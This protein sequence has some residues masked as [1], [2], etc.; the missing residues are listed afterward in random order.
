[1]APRQFSRLPIAKLPEEIMEKSWGAGLLATLRKA[2]CNQA[3]GRYESIQEFWEEFSR[4]GHFLESDID[5]E[6]TLVRSRLKTDVAI[7]QAASQPSF[8]AYAAAQSGSRPHSARIIVELPQRDRVE[9][10]SAPLKEAAVASN[11]NA[12]GVAVAPEVVAQ[13]NRKTSV[14]AGDKKTQVGKTDRNAGGRVKIKTEWLRVAFII[15]LLAA[16]IGIVASTYFHFAEPVFREGAISDA[17]NVNMRSEPGGSVVMVLP[18]GTKLRVYEERN[19]WSRVKV[20]E[21]PGAQP[22]NAALEGWVSSK[23]IKSD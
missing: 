21:L 4:L 20:M 5:P 2:T 23:F 8:Q 17:P 1:R 9:S 22:I 6:A 14:D 15:L 16:L 10:K 3:E 11:G 12:A 19:G 7:E 18:E 13:Q